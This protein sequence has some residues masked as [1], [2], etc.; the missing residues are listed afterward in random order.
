MI[1]VVQLG[2]VDYAT[3]LRLQQQLAALRKEEKIGDV[4]LLLDGEEFVNRTYVTL[5]RRLPDP[6]GLVNY[7]TELQSGVSK[8][9]I[10]SRLRGSTEGRKYARP[11]TGY[12]SIVM[13]TR[14]RSLLGRVAG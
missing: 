7:L 11:L 9:E 4:L 2:T 14:M 1:S 5:F 13:R 12:R 6:D 8:L 10:I 3:G